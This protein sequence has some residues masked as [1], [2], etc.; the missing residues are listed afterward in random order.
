MHDRYFRP[1]EPTFLE[2]PQPRSGNDLVLPVQVSPRPA[3]QAQA[4][5]PCDAASRRTPRPLPHL[6]TK[7]RR[8]SHRKKGK[9]LESEFSLQELADALSVGLR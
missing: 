2:G 3:Y 9:E 8:S 4:V 5:P 6:Q 7:P 1:L